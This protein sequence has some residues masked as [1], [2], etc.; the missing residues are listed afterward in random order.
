MALIRHWRG[1]PRG[2]RELPREVR[3]A[4]RYTGKN[5]WVDII[6]LSVDGQWLRLKFE[7][8]LTDYWRYATQGGGTDAF[9]HWVYTTELPPWE[10][11]DEPLITHDLGGEG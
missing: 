3:D 7:D 9:S 4:E 2:L 11:S 1:R 5:W 8:G 10:K 6:H